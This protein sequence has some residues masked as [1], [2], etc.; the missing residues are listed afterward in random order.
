MRGKIVTPT[1]RIK[2]RGRDCDDQAL[3]AANLARPPPARCREAR[4]LI[5]SRAGVGIGHVPAKRRRG[6][7]YCS[8]AAGDVELDTARIRSTRRRRMFRSWM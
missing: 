3:M 6:R 8:S 1:R 4:G 5:G 2:A 7:D